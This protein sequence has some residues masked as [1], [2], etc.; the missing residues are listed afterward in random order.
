MA[1]G[2]EQALPGVVPAAP[3]VKRP[4]LLSRI[5][6]ALRVWDRAE[7]ERWQDHFDDRGGGI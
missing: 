1:K 7:R 6:A 2:Y 4:S 5:R 3:K